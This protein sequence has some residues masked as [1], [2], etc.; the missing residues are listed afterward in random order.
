MPID[1]STLAAAAPGAITKETPCH[2]CGYNLVGL[3]PGSPCPECGTYIP[4]KRKA[5][6]KGDNL[7]EAPLRFLRRFAWACLFHALA[8]PAVILGTGFAKGSQGPAGPTIGVSIAALYVL[9]VWL[10]SAQRQKSERSI[11]DN[12]LD[13]PKLRLI[14]R[15]ASLTWPAY[16]A[17]IFLYNSQGPTASQSA[18]TALGA[19]DDI[20]KLLANLGFVPLLLTHSAYANW[21][22]DTG[23]DN[24]LRGSIWIIA[25]CSVL[26]VLGATLMLL[27][28]DPV[29][30]FIRVLLIFIRIAYYLAVVVA[31]I[32]VLQLAANAFGAISAS[33]ATIAR[34]ARIAERRAKELESATER[35]FSAPPPA[36]LYGDVI[37]SQHKEPATDPFAPQPAIGKLQRIES[38]DDL[39]AYDL[40]PDEPAPDEK[41]SGDNNP[42]R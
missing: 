37:Q 11:N 28:P 1:P 24:R 13:N 38:A 39:D 4:L 25:A 3:T 22:G 10:V 2:E 32:G 15:G 6:V 5:T 31:V 40:A 16:A 35:Q 34:D 41:S 14:T 30:N 7:A 26:I 33:K 8:F 19:A 36:D 18:L 42:L 9:S 29:D 17:F 12:I 23:L 27:F 20:L 21:A